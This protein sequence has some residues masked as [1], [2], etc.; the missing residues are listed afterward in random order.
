MLHKHIREAKEWVQ[1]MNESLLTMSTV[2]DRYELEWQAKPRS[3]DIKLG[4]HLA[5]QQK[6]FSK[7]PM[8]LSEGERELLKVAFKQEIAALQHY[9]GNG[10]NFEQRLQAIFDYR[11]WFQ[12][13]VYI[14]PNGGQ[15]SRLTNKTLGARSGAERL[16]ALLVPLLAAVASLYKR[17]QPDAPRLLALDEAFDRADADNTK[18]LIEYPAA[19]DFQWIMTGPQLNISG[20]RVPAG[21][22]YLMLHEKGTKVATAVPKIWKGNQHKD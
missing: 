5:R 15:R 7:P 9:Q 20:T 3:E 17:A 18:E 12:F 11:Q 10:M 6:L 13:D 19:Q 22:R 21:I 16:F 2:K 14:T 1:Q 4:T 8:K